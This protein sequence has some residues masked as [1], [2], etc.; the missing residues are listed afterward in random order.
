MNN[1]DICVVFVCNELYFNKFLYTCNLLI[2]K[3]LYKNDI[4][5]IIGDDLN[6]K[7][8]ILKNLDFIVKNK[9]IIKYLPN[10]QF[11]KDFYDIQKDLKKPMFFEKIF[12]FHKFHLFN[13][14]LKKWNYILYLDCGITIYSDISPIINLK[15]KNKLL[16]HSDAYPKYEWKL[17][18]QFD[19]ITPKYFKYSKKL[20]EEYNLN[21]DY[22]QTTM[23]LYDTDIIENNT[24]FDLLSLILKFPISLLNDQGIIALYFTN[25]KP[26]FEQI[27]IGEDDGIHFYYD[28]VPRKKSYKY[29]MTK[30]IWTDKI[31]K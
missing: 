18:N 3:G 1:N 17:A 14:F 16:A 12:L 23:L 10:I 13:T 7:I 22:F 27:K 28:Y 9:I 19:M 21:I 5:L 25:V 6:N 20:N 8:D 15:T 26:V 30:Q 4:C 29:I 2:N 24:F 31:D 11:E